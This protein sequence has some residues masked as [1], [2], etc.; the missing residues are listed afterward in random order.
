VKALSGAL[1][2]SVLIGLVC[3]GLALMLSFPVALS[4]AEIPEVP[5]FF[6]AA[7][8][9]TAWS[10]ILRSIGLKER[11]A[12]DARVI[13]LPQDSTIHIEEIP[14]KLTA[15]RILVLEGDSETARTLGIRATAQHVRVRRIHDAHQPNLSIAWEESVDLPVF[16]LPRTAKIVTWD[17]VSGAPLTAILRWG[18]GSVLWVAASIGLEGYERFPFLLN[19]LYDMGVH[20][21]FESSRLAAFFDFAFERNRDEG[22]LAR[23][24]RRMGIAAVHVGAW[25]FFERKSIL[26]HRLKKLIEACHREGILVYAWLELP[27]VSVKFWKS[28]P[29][30]RE[31]TA[32]LKDA[33]GDDGWRLAM[34]LNNPDCRRAVVRGIRSTI[35][36]FDWDGVNLAEL[37]FEGADGLSKPEEFTPLSADVRREVEY[38][39]GFD[40]VGL[41]QSKEPDPEKLRIFL[42]YRVDLAAR[43]QE[44][45]I[46]ELE[47]M[48]ALKPH[49]DLVLT[50][51]DDR[52]DT[53]MRDAIGADAARLLR[54]L[55]D[56]DLSFIIEDPYTVWHLGPKRYEEIAA[57]YRPLTFRQ[58]RLGVDINIVERGGH[59]YPTSKQTGVELTELI[60]TSAESF[61]TVMYYHTGSI[62]GL[63]AP[64][65][66]YASSVVR[67]C[68]PVSGGLLVD[69]PL[70]V[71]VRWSG[72][73]TLDG[74]DW[75]VR[76]KKRVLIPVGEH[77]LR[78]ADTDI[79]ALVTD[80]TGTLENA[81]MA[82]GGVEIA[83][84]SQSRAFA[85]MSRKPKHL[86]VDGVEM[87]LHTIGKYMVFLPRGKHSALI[88]F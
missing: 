84:T 56:H 54:M 60:H 88:L 19:T 53:T 83:Y 58:D 79:P 20:P 66:P 26:N 46:D 80:F 78:P 44:F 24:L 52:F 16:K 40:P 22:K 50:H 5:G 49:L 76:D 1:W 15:G 32:L 25:E 42:N 48:C 11:S 4:A 13:V 68:E 62:T 61:S 3:V 75:P 51:V 14:G 41:F 74:R 7:G 18:H 71:G 45:W 55:D 29:E 37:Y 27:H 82:P 67:R 69:S 36:R 70:G 12:E 2:R 31:K 59:V 63:D 86:V 85:R 30:W 17:R 39:Y 21:L 64:F 87:T 8:S 23:E 77:V 38:A 73:V 6:L 34:N 10:S 33:V 9:E 81:A 65:L 57:R 28:H 35:E 43:L 47:K 72:P